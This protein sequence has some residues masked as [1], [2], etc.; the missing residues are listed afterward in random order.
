MKH[1]EHAISQAQPSLVQ[2]DQNLLTKFQRM[3]HSTATE[4]ELG[5]QSSSS[6]SHRFSFW[7][8][9]SFPTPGT[10]INILIRLSHCSCLLSPLLSFLYFEQVVAFGLRKIN[11]C[12]KHK[13]KVTFVVKVVTTKVII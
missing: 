5:C 8:V 1:L 10:H 13:K 6:T 4:D 3:V 11:A 12:F 9:S 7:C 2:F